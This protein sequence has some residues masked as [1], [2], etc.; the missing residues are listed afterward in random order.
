MAGFAIYVSV[1]ALALRREHIRVARFAG[2][3]ARE[4]DRMGCDL[5]ESIATIVPVLAET[6]RHHVASYDKKDDEGEHEK[7][8]K[9]KKMPC[10]LE[11]CSS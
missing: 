5:I 6:L 4:L 3:V 9:P 1:L 7:S 8:S 11:H 10:I 2:L